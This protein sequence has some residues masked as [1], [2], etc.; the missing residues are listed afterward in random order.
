MSLLVTIFGLSILVILHE[1][2]HYFAGKLCGMRILR[3]SVGFGPP[4]LMKKWRGTEWQLA[5]IPLG[6]FVH[7]DGMGPAD[8][9]QEAEDP[10]AFRNKPVWQRVFVIL[11]GPAMNWA[12]AAIF[13][14]FSAATVGLNQYDPKST[15]I[16]E[17][18]EGGAASEAGLKNGDRVLRIDG[19]EL[20]GWEQMVTL[21]EKS[22]DSKLRFQILRNKELRSFDVTPKNRGNLGKIGVGPLPKTLKLGLF[23]SA[24]AGLIGAWR[25]TTHQASILSSMLT[26]G[27]EGGQLSGLPGIVKTVS[28]HARQG[29]RKFL[30][31]LAWLSVGLF[32]LNLAPIPALDG[33][34]LL[35][36]SAETIR[37]RPLDAHL[38]G[39]IHAIGFILLMALMIYVSIRDVIQG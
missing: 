39:I 26:G 13:I 38:E 33:G 15:R 16:G 36:L 8:E 21:I 30:E 7:I 18:V 22:P 14:G 23:D 10:N 27:G 11:A 31:T 17:V 4:L 19:I 6:G 29:L 25:M 9:D 35:F 12:L 3:F 24:K 20:D 28:A 1:F 5:A 34:R 32:L 2:G 37:G